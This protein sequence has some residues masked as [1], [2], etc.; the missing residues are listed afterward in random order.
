MGFDVVHLNLH[1]TFTTPHGGGGP[2]SGPIGV[3]ED[4]I[5]F[6]PKPMIVK[7]GDSY[8]LDYDRPESIGK[9]HSFYGNFGVNVRAYTYIKTM[10]AEGLKKSKPNGSIKCQ[11]SNAPSEKTIINCPLTGYA[12]MNSF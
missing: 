6:L 10:G 2:G 8:K 5:P 12:N 3:R 1:K 9:I 11:L 4:L 7:E